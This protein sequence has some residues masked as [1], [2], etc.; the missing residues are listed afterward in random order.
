VTLGNSLGLNVIAE[1]VETAVQ[2]QFLADAG[3]VTYQGNLFSHPL[4]IHE[5]E[6]IAAV[7][8]DDR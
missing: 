7:Q 6:G 8:S 1:G 5:F 3:C 4:G 2:Y